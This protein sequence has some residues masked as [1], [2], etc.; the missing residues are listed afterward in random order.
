MT[1]SPARKVGDIFV[2]GEMFSGQNMDKLMLRG[3]IADI[4]TEE[5]TGMGLILPRGQS[6][7]A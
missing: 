5:R 1:I 3:G 7:R 2:K 4:V 6:L